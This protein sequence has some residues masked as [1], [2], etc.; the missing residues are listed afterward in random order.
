MQA[1][2]EGAVANQFVHTTLS[3]EVALYYAEAEAATKNS[4]QQ[5]VEI[6]LEY[7]D[8]EV[9]DVSDAHGCSCHDIP[10]GS[11]ASNFAVKH[12]VVMLK[13]Y[14]Q[15]S[16]LG[17]VLST[18]ALRLDGTGQ[19]SLEGFLSALPERVRSE[20]KSCWRRDP[21]STRCRKPEEQESPD[22]VRRD[23]AA[24][25]LVLNRAS[26]KLSQ[27]IEKLQAKKSLIDAQSR[28]IQE[29]ACRETR[30]KE[31]ARVRKLEEERRE[32]ERQEQLQRRKQ[33]EERL[34]KKYQAEKARGPRIV[35]KCP[36]QRDLIENFDREVLQVALGNG[37]YIALWD[38]AWGQTW[39]NI[40]TSL[41]NQLTGLGCHQAHPTLVALSPDSD[42]YFVQFSNGSRRWSAAAPDSFTEAV[43]D[44]GRL[45]VVAFGERGSWFV[46]WPDG[47]WQHEGLPGSLCSIL[48]SNSHRP[49]AKL[50]ISGAGFYLDEP[51]WF[52]RWRDNEHPTWKM[53]NAPSEL[54][55][56]VRK[57]QEQWGQVRSVEFGDYGEWVLRWT[58]WA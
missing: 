55:E 44:Y 22:Q 36:D 35:A 39:N 54:S 27:E 2:Q 8:G 50:S 49:V 45:S 19:R 32:H 51:A 5:V 52:I 16:R 12:G 10:P 18:A 41:E 53:R 11:K 20:V 25:R 7:F 1:L 13:G 58:P 24:Q 4:K 40:P 43:A 56:K 17:K 9:I 29:R 21:T 46:Q 57:V 37:G 42:I 34:K 15:P 23:D 33:E 38:R 26:D 3:P 14:V 31:E 30:L 28:Q 47:S 6:D 48:E